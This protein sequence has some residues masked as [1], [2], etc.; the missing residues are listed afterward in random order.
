MG[1]HQEVEPEASTSQYEVHQCKS[2]EEEGTGQ[3]GEDSTRQGQ[4]AVVLWLTLK[5]V[6]G[7][8]LALRFV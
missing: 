1:S 2:E 6:P 8:N 3:Q 5:P 4:N 7:D